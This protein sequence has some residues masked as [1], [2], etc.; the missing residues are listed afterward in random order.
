MCFFTFVFRSIIFVRP[1]SENVIIQLNC[2][3]TKSARH[4]SLTAITS[5][6]QLV[7]C[8]RTVYTAQTWMI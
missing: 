8:L 5:S 1:T 3:N 6:L 4:A 2:V 7:T